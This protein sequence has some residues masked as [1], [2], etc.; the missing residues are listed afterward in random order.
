MVCGK[1]VYGCLIKGTVNL[2]IRKIPILEK[3][4]FYG[5]IVVKQRPKNMV[6]YEVKFFGLVRYGKMTII[7]DSVLAKILTFCYRNV[8]LACTD[9][10][11]NAPEILHTTY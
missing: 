2:K 10:L 7:S 5:S 11:R 8:F 1:V 9:F 3:L 6:L 4:Q